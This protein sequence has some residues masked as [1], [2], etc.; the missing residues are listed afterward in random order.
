M[1]KDPEL[2][3]YQNTEAYLQDIKLKFK[4]LKKIGHVNI[5]GYLNLNYESQNLEDLD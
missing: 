1:K 2:I 5:Y 4:T 3:P